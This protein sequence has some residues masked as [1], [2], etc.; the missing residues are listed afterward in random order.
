M[1]DRLRWGLMGTARINRTIVARLHALPRH[2]I[3]A[4]ASRDVDRAA[5]YA[6]RWRIPAAV[7]SYEAL[8]AREDVDVVYI[9]LPNT[10]HAE[11]AVRA[12]EAGKH[13]LCEKPLATTVPEVDAMIDAAR[14]TGVRISEAF[15]YR[16]HTQTATVRGIV[17]RGDLGV[18]RLVRGCFS[19]DLDRPQ[20]I[21]WSPELGGGALWDVGCYPVSYARTVLGR[22]PLEV[23]ALASRYSTG[24][25]TESAGVLRFDGAALALFDCSFRAPFRSFMEIVGTDAVLQVPAPFRPGPASTLLLTRGDATSAVDVAGEESCD[26]ELEDMA[27]QILD[28]EPPGL[29]LEDS[30]ANTATIVALYRS[31]SEGRAVAPAEVT[32]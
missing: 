1:A 11:W 10:M 4:V 7:G 12:A 21:R 17:A 5:T 32:G 3:V 15:M 30:R 29:P 23:M 14:R 18:V 28:A 16:H 19:F 31:A 26:G 24:V 27:R 9:P 25:D 6:T 20:D 13:V 8:L 22:E 2:E